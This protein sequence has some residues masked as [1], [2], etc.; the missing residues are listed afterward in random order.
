MVAPFAFAIPAHDRKLIPDGRFSGTMSWVMAIML[1][2][3]LLA[4]A[5]AISLGN[6]ASQGSDTLGSEATVQILAPDPATR[7]AQQKSLTDQLRRTPGILSVTAVPEAESRKLIEPWLGDAADDADIPVPALI[8]VRFEGPPSANALKVV[9]QNLRRVAPSVRIDSHA[10]W[11]APFVALMQTLFL[12]ALSVMVLL[13]LATAATV[14]L[15][16]RG[17]LNTHRTTIEIMHMMGSTDVQ[18]ARLF[19]RRVALDAL[20]G[21][22]IGLGAAVL[23]LWL[24]GSRFAALEPGLLADAGMPLYGWLLLAIIPVGVAALA[25]LT[26]RWTVL[27]AL[28]KII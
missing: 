13:L 16:V 11:M 23:V 18:A 15:S 25:M 8:D 27:S 7:A 5:A 21:G 1:F 20:F 9:Q 19:Q 10:S 26:A 3:T 24:L 22:M 2:L 14:V 12:L 4:A 17:A 6:A 28:K